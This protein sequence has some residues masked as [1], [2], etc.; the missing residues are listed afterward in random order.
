MWLPKI[1]LDTSF[2]GIVVLLSLLNVVALDS[3]SL[4]TG[5]VGQLDTVDVNVRITIVE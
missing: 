4:S 5:I 3:N 2:K 1:T